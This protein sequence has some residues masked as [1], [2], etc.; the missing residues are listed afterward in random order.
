M[1]AE[2]CKQQHWRMPNDNWFTAYTAS[3]HIPDPI[4]IASYNIRESFRHLHPEFGQLAK[5][6]ND[7]ST[8]IAGSTHVQRT[9]DRCYKQRRAP[10]KS[11]L[12]LRADTTLL[13]RSIRARLGPWVPTLAWRDLKSRYI[14]HRWGLSATHAKFGYRHMYGAI[15]L[16]NVVQGCSRNAIVKAQWELSDRG[17]PY[18]LTVHDSISLVVPRNRDAVLRARKDI[19]DVCGPGNNLGFDWAFVINPS[20]MAVHN[21]LYEGPE[22]PE[23]WWQELEKR[24]R[25]ITGGYNMIGL[26]IRKRTRN[27][28]KYLARVYG[29]VWTYDHLASWWCDDGERCV[30]RVCASMYEE[31]RMPPNY[32]LYGDGTPQQV[33]WNA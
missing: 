18:Q 6:L 29:G 30:S 26:K 2:L 8:Q 12:E 14:M 33:H 25:I 9:L 24:K 4:S 17:Y 23:S 7:T 27:K 28:S 15:F 11:R 13:G 22:R 20:E 31:D 10:L 32:W 1:V 21:S 5:W 19:I 3:E 16:E